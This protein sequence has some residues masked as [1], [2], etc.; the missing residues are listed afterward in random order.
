MLWVSTE[1]LQLGSIRKRSARPARPARP[2]GPL[3]CAGQRH[4]VCH[5]LSSVPET[6]ETTWLGLFDMGM[7]FVPSTRRSDTGGWV[8]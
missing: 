5:D 2:A 3:P 7:T 8:E 6:P 4:Y 1:D